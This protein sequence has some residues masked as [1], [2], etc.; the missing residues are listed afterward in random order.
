MSYVYT[1]I[2]VHI[3]KYISLSPVTH[4]IRFKR[5][6]KKERKKKTDLQTR[7][8][9]SIISVS[10]LTGQRHWNWKCELDETPSKNSSL[11]ETYWPID[12]V[13]HLS[14]HLATTA[15][16]SFPFSSSVSFSLFFSIFLFP[17]FP[18][19]VTARNRN[20]RNRRRSGGHRP[21]WRKVGVR[22]DDVA[23][24][25]DER[26][27]IEESRSLNETHWPI[28]SSLHSYYPLCPFFFPPLLQLFY[29]P[30]FVGVGQFVIPFRVSL[31][32]QG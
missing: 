28:D 12:W 29:R 24:R 31:H 25:T 13:P 19:F 30:A 5:D 26:G 20:R 3:Y 8:Y 18:R 7:S 23:A 9:G 16:F 4:M 27:W 1:Y 6:W 14:H 22:R 15:H 21:R 17:L 32:W 2:Y 11:N 10:R